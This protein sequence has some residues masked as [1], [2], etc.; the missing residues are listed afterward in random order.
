MDRLPRFFTVC[1]GFVLSAGVVHGATR[2]VGADLFGAVLEESLATEAATQGWD[3]EIAFGGTVGGSDALAA[4]EASIA[5]LAAPGGKESLDPRFRAWPLAF[6][7]TAL[8][9]HPDNPVGQLTW[10]QVADVFAIGDDFNRWGRLGG[11]GVWENR[12]L[13]LH[14]LRNPQSLSLEVL[15]AR[16]LEPREISEKI[17]YWDSSE[18]LLAYVAQTADA[19][20]LVSSLGEGAG[21]KVLALSPEGSGVPYRPSP[22]ALLYGDYPLNLAYF[23]AIGPNPTEET[24]AVA[25]HLLG[26]AVAEVLDDAGYVPVPSNERRQFVLELDLGN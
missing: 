5:I 15:K 13:R 17:R 9:V 11:V 8:V 25:R 4:G 22:A 3:L 21:V 6:E 18:E 19:L 12:P 1:L 20:G 16:V 10:S 2:L 24:L 14:A 23:L 7:M 26:G